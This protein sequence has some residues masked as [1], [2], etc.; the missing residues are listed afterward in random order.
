MIFWD[1]FSKKAVINR[2]KKNKKTVLLDC[3]F[4]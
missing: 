4:M 3:F 2:K 1:V